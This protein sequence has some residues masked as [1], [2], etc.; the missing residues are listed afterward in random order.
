MLPAVDLGKVRALARS[1][2]V[3]YGREKLDEVGEKSIGF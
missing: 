1:L 2:K 3:G